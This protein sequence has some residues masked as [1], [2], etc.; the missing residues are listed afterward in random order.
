MKV[1]TILTLVEGISVSW[2]EPIVRQHLT[3]SV[4][5]GLKQIPQLIHDDPDV[6]TIVTHL[7]SDLSQW[8]IND[9]VEQLSALLTY[10]MDTQIH[11]GI[12]DSNGESSLGYAEEENIM[13][14][15][16]YVN[17][18]VYSYVTACWEKANKLPA[19]QQYD[20]LISLLTGAVSKYMQAPRTVSRIQA[21]AS[22]IIHELVH[23][24]QHYKQR[25]KNR[26]SDQYEYRGYTTKKHKYKDAVE[27][28]TTT[29]GTPEDYTIYKAS[30]QELP[31]FAHEAALD[32]IRAHEITKGM[33]PTEVQRILN[34]HIG[35]FIDVDLKPL[36]GTKYQKIVNRFTKLLYNEVMNYAQSKR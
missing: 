8:V 10:H 4:K 5:R 26:A 30:P 1:S 24:N 34:Q 7:L 36:A 9:L 15:A 14:N 28:L 32:L 25:L 21:I 20:K 6:Q 12:A 17:Q 2:L 31:S 22:V 16:Q 13:L 19:D 29:G 18:L 23:V 33:D 35:D 11:V 27:R 3:D